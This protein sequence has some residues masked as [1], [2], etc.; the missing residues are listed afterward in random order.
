M[1]ML[2]I[3]LG[4]A[5]IRMVGHLRRST[6]PNSALAKSL[7]F[8]LTLSLIRRGA[9]GTL[10]QGTTVSD[11]VNVCAAL[12]GSDSLMRALSCGVLHQMKLAL[13]RARYRYALFVY[14]PSVAHAP[15]M[16]M[17]PETDR[18]RSRLR[19]ARDWR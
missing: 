14:G 3:A 19:R 15:T 10:R 4:N 11:I 18:A 2:L 5:L 12:F 8:W 7:M 9:D 6:A 13:L 16:E 17:R 1:P